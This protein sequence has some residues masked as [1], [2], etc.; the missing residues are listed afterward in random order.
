MYG[1][2]FRYRVKPGKD[3]ELMTLFTEFRDNPPEGYVGSVT[4]RL[5]AGDGQYMTAAA[6]RDKQAYLDNAQSPQQSAWFQRFREL[7]VDDPDW[8]DGEILLG[9]VH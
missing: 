5:D 8:N 1:T 4:Y 3:E 2:V 7:L 9:E 6:H